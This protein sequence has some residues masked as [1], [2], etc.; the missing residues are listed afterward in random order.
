MNSLIR[1]Q[2]SQTRQKR[3]LNFHK[4]CSNFQLPNNHVT[5]TQCSEQIRYT[6]ATITRTCT[7]MSHQTPFSV[8]FFIIVA[9][10]LAVNSSDSGDREA[11]QDALIFS[12][13]AP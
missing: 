7:S 12:M 8:H 9:T 2:M 10:M 6:R 13:S 4:Y 1:R 5:E 3:E 11:L